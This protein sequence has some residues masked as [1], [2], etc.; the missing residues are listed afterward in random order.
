MDLDTIRR[1][2]VHIIAKRKAISAA[3]Q[4]GTNPTTIDRLLLIILT[5]CVKKIA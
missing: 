3:I 1:D 4:A 2:E 5:N